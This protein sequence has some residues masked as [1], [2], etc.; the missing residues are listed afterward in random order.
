MVLNDI[1]CLKDIFIKEAYDYAVKAKNH[2]SD[3]H[4]FHGG[5]LSDKQK[6][7]YEG[8]LGEKIFK[9]YLIEKNITFAEDDSHHTKADNYDFRI[10]QYLVDVKTRTEDYHTRTLEMVEQ[11]NKKPKD[12]Y[13][14]VR[15]YTDSYKGII[16]GWFGKNDIKRINRVENNGYLDNYVF[17]DKEL[18]NI[19]NLKSFI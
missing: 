10:K 19:D 9:Q 7:M 5:S 4:S 18:R 3:R 2:L 1:I 14:S 11:F 17:Y 6:K 16:V 15:L 13:V 8:K 12:I